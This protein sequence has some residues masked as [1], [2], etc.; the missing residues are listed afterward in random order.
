[1]AEPEDNSVFLQD[2]VTHL[3]V[4]A[5]QANEMFQHLKGAGFSKQEA[6]YISAFVFSGM[7]INYDDEAP[8]IE[9]NDELD[10]FGDEDNGEVNF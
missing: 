1:M 8:D 6:L 10:D 7:L 5:I 3:S 4:V 9:Y 2:G